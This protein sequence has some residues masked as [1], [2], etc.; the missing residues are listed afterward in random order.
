MAL[1]NKDSNEIIQSAIDSL[2]ANTGLNALGG[3]SKLRAIIETMGVLTKDAYDFFKVSAGMTLIYTATDKYLDY[4]GAIFGM[5]RK[6]GENA[7]VMPG[8]LTVKVYVNT[9]TFGDINEGQ[10]IIIPE[11]TRIYAIQNNEILNYYTVESYVLQA[12]DAFFY[13]GVRSELPGA[14]YNIPSGK[15]K[16]IDFA[17]YSGYSSQ[18]S[19]KVINLFPM[20]NGKSAES[21]EDFRFRIINEFQRL[22]KG[23][24]FAIK[25]AA[26]SVPGVA[27]AFIIPN[28]KGLGTITLLIKS[29]T[30]SVTTDLLEAVEY[31]VNQV[32]SAGTKVFV[33][34]PTELLVRFIIRLN[35]KPGVSSSAIIN[36]Q[37]A[38]KNALYFKINNLDPG[39]GF[40]INDLADTVRLADSNINSIG[41]P[42]KYF[43][44]IYV[45]TPVLDTYVRKEIISDFY[46]KEM[47]KLLLSP[48]NPVVFI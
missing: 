31:E 20:F 4:I 26:F 16:Y 32:K 10:D 40:E 7:L 34:G 1:F 22:Q 9:G 23:N 48:T 5:T 3:G 46:V 36:A 30:P 21:D 37:E 47:D 13:I 14:V 25:M 12:E 19:L 41:F 2:Q 29:V 11:G 17:G 35:F 42:N 6:T 28:Q 8:A 44:K 15:L 38:V 39:E 24:E 18:E 45:D 33:T 27:D 43:E